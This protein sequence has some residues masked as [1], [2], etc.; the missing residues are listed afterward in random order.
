MADCSIPVFMKINFVLVVCLCACGMPLF[1]QHYNYAP[2]TLNIPFVQQRGDMALGIGWGHASGSLDLQAT[3]AP[4]KRLV[5]TANYFGARRGEVRRRQDIGTDFYMGDLAIGFC[6]PVKMGTASLMAGFGGGR[7]FSH[8]ELNN[9]AR[10]NFQRWYVQ[11]GYA[12]QSEYF[13]AAVA[14]RLSRL[15][16]SQGDISFSINPIDLAYIRNI[17]AKNPIVLPE[18]G[19][20]A[21][22]VYRPIY[23]GL[24]ISSIIQNTALWDFSRLNAALVLRIR[25]E[26]TRRR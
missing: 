8:Y 7:V 14:F 4:L 15:N 13:Q 25:H 21:G 17:E 20:Q 3:Y 24:A 12:Y 11:P 23:L 1:G 19:I 18:L 22:I 5:V 16:Y 26:S 2:N 6:E 9:S 10:L